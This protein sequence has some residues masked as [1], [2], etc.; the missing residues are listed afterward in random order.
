MSEHDEQRYTATESE[1]KMKDKRQRNLLSS[2]AGSKCEDVQKS[3][4]F[5]AFNAS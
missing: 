3:E 2:S 4:D 1:D 5:E